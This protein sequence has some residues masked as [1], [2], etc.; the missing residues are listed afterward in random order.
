[1]ASNLDFMTSNSAI[2]QGN[3]S[4]MASIFQKT[5]AEIAKAAQTA[6]AK[7]KVKALVAV[8]VDTK[9]ASLAPGEV[10]KVANDK[11]KMEYF[12]GT[13]D[14]KVSKPLTSVS[15]AVDAVNTQIRK[16]E[17]VQATALRTAQKIEIDETKQAL[18]DAGLS[19]KEIGKIITAEKAANTAEVTQLKGL[20]S[21]PNLQYGVRDATT[22]TFVNNSVNGVTT[23]PATSLT[24]LLTYNDA[25][26]SPTIQTNIQSANE[27]L[28]V[29]QL[30]KGITQP[31]LPSGN[32]TSGVNPYAI[33]QAL[34]NGSIIATKDATGNT[35]GYTVSDAVAAAKGDQ[36]GFMDA[37][38][39][40][41]AS[42]R[43]L[44]LI[45]NNDVVIGGKANVVADADG[46]YFVNDASGADRYGKQK[47][48]IDTGRVDGSGNKIFAEVST[49]N[50]KRNLVS[51]V[52]N[53]IQQP[54]GTFTYG[55]VDSTDYTHIE[56]FNPIKSLVIAGMSAGFGAGAG[57]LSG[58]SGSAA[59]A[60][61]GAVGGATGAALSG[62]NI[63]KGALLGGLGGFTLGEVQAAAK[64]AGGYEKLLGQVANRNFSSFTQAVQD[65]ATFANSAAGSASGV[66]GGGG[67]FA[68]GGES[69]AS[70]DFGTD[71]SVA[72]GGFTNGTD[73]ANAATTGTELTNYGTTG[74]TGLGADMTYNTS[75]SGQGIK[76]GYDSAGNI[77]DATT[78]L[79]FTGSGINFAKDAAGNFILDAAGNVLDAAT[80]LP[81]QG[82]GVN[83]V[84]F[85]TGNYVQP[86]ANTGGLLDKVV[87]LGSNLVDTL[88]VGGTIIA[89]STIIPEIVKAVTPG[90]KTD[91][92]VYTA[93]LLT[94]A[95]FGK[96]GST[97]WTQYYNNLFK[98]QGY[99]AGQFLGYDIMNKIN[100]PAELMGLLGTSAQATPTTTTA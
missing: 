48:L 42:A 76:L 85:D 15:S 39:M 36:S 30:L 18:K 13:Y 27:S 94:D 55:G 86:S 60:V 4:S 72:N 79:P 66:D 24:S 71:A 45:L 14:G 64:A 59:T 52:S 2:G 7:D 16:A 57:A 12:V 74:T 80:G 61:G 92:T 22:N 3:G 58:L 26:I 100:V 70:I 34:D 95:M 78:K 63:L 6:A 87:D 47:P 41:K 99:G 81:F 54:N 77:I 51:V 40:S 90:A 83:L 29:F 65:A 93:P 44:G 82:E 98:R 46:N 32:T 25:T 73:V 8:T 20:L 23:K 38:G 97:D 84:N 75:A 19:T 68:G 50:S 53:Y 91:N 10:I 56:G 21:A 49:D 62:S 33:Y 89:G 5:P 9:P 35:T 17:T 31:F 88:G 67:G 69:Q 43:A 1:M 37:T 28:A 96:N 11:G